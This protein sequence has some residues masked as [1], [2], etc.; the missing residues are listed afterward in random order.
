MF[1][2]YIEN[3]VKKVMCIAK[4]ITH[5]ACVLFIFVCSSA[6]AGAIPKVAVIAEDQSGEAN[7]AQLE[8]VE[9][10]AR[11][12]VL[13]SSS[14]NLIGRR[15]IE[16][17][18]DQSGS[19]YK[20]LVNDK[21]MLGRLTG[22][23]ILIVA[24]VLKNS[25]KKR[26]EEISAYG[27]TERRV[28]TISDAEISLK[29]IAIGDEFQLLQ[30]KGYGKSQETAIVNAKTN[31]I[32]E[33][34]GD[35][36]DAHSLIQNEEVVRDDTTSISNGFIKD[37]KIVSGPEATENGIYEVCIS[38][39][40]PTG[41]GSIIFQKTISQRVE[42]PRA[43]DICATEIR[44]TLRKINLVRETKT[45]SP[46]THQL[47]VDAVRGGANAQ[48]LDVFI[49]GQFHGN[50]PYKIKMEE[51]SYEISIRKSGQTLWENRVQ[52]SKAMAIRPDIN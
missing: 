19:A 22:A 33:A 32:K 37:Y 35:A 45:Q 27:M 20:T 2:D 1:D 23:D 42:T 38:A 49:N 34:L 10:H 29:V 18:L 17:I 28:F 5:R 11:S 15:H 50:T 39:R 13:D 12:G 4:K 31:A 40:I 3:L 14:C 44:H 7:I 46:S 24:T 21:V 43:L 52:L 6:L 26:S 25:S 9:S 47:V 8:M 30:T 51:G 36:I 48:G 41:K 16:K